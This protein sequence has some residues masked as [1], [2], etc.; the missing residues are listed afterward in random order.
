MRTCEYLAGEA[1]EDVGNAFAESVV[2][3]AAPEIARGKMHAERQDFRQVA[4]VRHLGEALRA[5][6]AG[7]ARR[8]GGGRFTRVE[9]C[10]K[11]GLVRT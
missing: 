4:L 11:P 2:D 3:E 5:A 6:E 10:M 9:V 8:S 7:A 1:G